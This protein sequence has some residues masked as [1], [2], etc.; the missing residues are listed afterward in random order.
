MYEHA[1]VNGLVEEGCNNYKAVN[2]GINF[3]AI[4]LKLHNLQNVTRS[5]VV[6]LAGLTNVMESRTIPDI[7]FMT[8]ESYLVERR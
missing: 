3:V 7:S 8:T 6:V 1:K 5:I 4:S 2:G